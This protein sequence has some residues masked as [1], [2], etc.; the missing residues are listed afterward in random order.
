MPEN[1]IKIFWRSPAS[2]AVANALGYF[3][4]S[5]MMRK[6]CEEYFEYDEN[7]DIA[8][9]IVPADQFVPVPGKKNI[10]FTMWEAIDVPESYIKGLNEADLVI[11][12]ST[13]C[14]EIFRPITNKPIRVCYEGVEPDIFTFKE[15]RFPDFQDGE[16]FRM[17]WL[18]AP[19]PRKG[20]F[21][22]IELSKIVEKMPNLE[23]YI[24]TTANKKLT[25]RQ[26][27]IVTILRLRKMI[28]NKSF[29]TYWKNWRGEWHNIVGSFKRFLK[30]EV[31]GKVT[32]MGTHNNI[33]FD[34]RK[35]P[36]DELVKLY[37]S[38][39]CF[40][41][42]HTG[43]GWGLTLC[44]AMATGCPS[45]A[46][47]STGVLDFFNRDVGYPV[48]CDA[49]PLEMQNYKITARAFIP[50][51]KD[52][53]QQVFTVL[54][55]YNHALKRGRKASYS[56][57]TEFTWKKS[58]KRMRDIVVSEFIRDDCPARQPMI[59]EACV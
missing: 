56:V 48:R 40:L 50:D 52:F 17:L 31:E 20:Y 21:S 47:Y 9:T 57:R 24:K 23:I 35:I 44:E 19:N 12:P 34:S 53:I 15:R 54:N 3:Q 26:L 42:P 22:V 36:M 33:I 49:K 29:H 18:G 16:K 39:H 51:T 7:A 10:L 41:A 38:S 27:I 58:A 6:Y 32:K 25:L 55:D 11:V 13:F 2:N 8:L 43:E 14:L 28:F 5:S 1:K 59:E 45:V 4:H 37:H 30:P 46:S